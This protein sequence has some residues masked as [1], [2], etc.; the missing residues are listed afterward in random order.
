[1]TAPTPSKPKPRAATAGGGAERPSPS[2]PKGRAAVWTDERGDEGA[3]AR[4]EDGGLERPGG[5][6]GPERGREDGGL[7]RPGGERGP[8]KRARRLLRWYPA[9]WRARYGP[10]FTELLLADL[11]ERPRCWRRDADVARGGLRARLSAAGLAG[12]PADPA[13]AARA[14]LATLACSVAGFLVFGATVWAQLSVAWQW[15]APADRV[16]GVAMVVMSAAML[17]FAVLALLAAAPVG[18]AVARAWRGDRGLRWPVLLAVG[19]AA[20]LV[21]GG[22]HFQNGWP[23]TGGHWWPHQGLVPGGVAAFAWACTLPVTSYWAHPAA[24]ASFPAAELGWLIA[25][26]AAIGC[27]LTGVRRLVRRLDLPPGVLRYQAWLAGAA[28][29][30]MAAFLAGALCWVAEGGAGPR[31][32]FRTGLIDAVALAAM[33]LALVTGW[34]ALRQLLNR[35]RPPVPAQ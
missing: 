32:L 25:A 16:T 24:L 13:A 31:G 29:A 22:H 10:E 23:G 35:Q 9:D 19:S 12:H 15:A 7:E 30:G 28:G 26:P 5:E 8:E 17:L 3:G 14:A 1:M 20:V 2:E 27:L 4:R 18:W 6:R 11:A 21:A 34:L 33:G